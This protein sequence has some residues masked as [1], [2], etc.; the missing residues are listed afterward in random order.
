M[1]RIIILL[2]TVSAFLYIGGVQ[3]MSDKS[4]SECVG[5]ETAGHCTDKCPLGSYNIGISKTNEPLCK[6]EPTG[7]V[8]GD[9][10]P[11]DSPKCEN[12]TLPKVTITIPEPTEKP[13][14]ESVYM[15]YGK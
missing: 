9:S 7:C 6:L 3:A 8:N 10:I 11:L 14:Q 12:N 4:Y 13:T 15:G 5:N 1:K 2:V